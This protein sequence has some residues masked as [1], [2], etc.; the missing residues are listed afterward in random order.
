MHFLSDSEEYLVNL[1]TSAIMVSP[2]PLSADSTSIAIVGL[3]GAGKST[4][5]QQMLGRS[6]EITLETLG[7]EADTWQTGQYSLRLF[8]LGG[9]E[10]FQKVLWQPYIQQ[11][12][13]IIFVVDGTNPAWFAAAAV[14][15]KKVLNWAENSSP[16]L[17]LWNKSDLSTFVRFAEESRSFGFS[18]IANVRPGPIC[19]FECSL[20]YQLNVAWG[21]RWFLQSLENYLLRKPIRLQALRVC[22][23]NDQ[24]ILAEAG[25]A[26]LFEKTLEFCCSIL[27]RTYI[28]LRISHLLGGNYALSLSSQRNYCVAIFTNETPFELGQQFAA[29]ALEVLEESLQEKNLPFPNQ[30]MITQWQAKLMKAKRSWPQQHIIEK[31]CKNEWTS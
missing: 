14:A 9:N 16:I 21:L 24:V 15:F 10:A 8:D 12:Q 22:S 25:Q 17:V 31:K 1:L 7:V 13:G 28:N 18:S 2:L 6:P 30:E 5:F 4:L 20:R 29:F 23:R 26:N 27:Q 11:A 3:T 19:L